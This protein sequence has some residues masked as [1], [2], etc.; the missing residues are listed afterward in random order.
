MEIESENT[1]ENIAFENILKRIDKLKET[2]SN[3]ILISQPF[4]WNTNKTDLGIY[5]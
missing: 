3:P 1:E 4:D 5:I 2:V